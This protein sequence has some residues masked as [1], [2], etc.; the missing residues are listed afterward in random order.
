MGREATKAVGNVWYEARKKASEYDDR[1]LS[2]ES[3]SEQLGMSVSALADAEL[4]LSKCM[5]PDKAVMMAD[6]YNAPHL[7]NWYCSNECPIGKGKNLATKVEP[8]DRV[9]VKLLKSLSVGKL[10]EIKEK[11][12][13]IAEDGQ[14][15]DDQVDDLEEVQAYLDKVSERISEL[16]LLTIIAR[17]RKKADDGKH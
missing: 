11:L 1:L 8:I 10:D 7:L 4:G 17:N 6:R 14:I 12:M 16:K 15:S 5:P 3:A 13:E 2:R 9:T